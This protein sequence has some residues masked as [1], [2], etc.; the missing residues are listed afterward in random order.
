MFA[1]PQSITYATVA[2][3][4][5]AISRGDGQSEYRLNDSGTVYHLTLSHQFKARNRVVIRLRRDAYAS[6]PVVPTSN[7]LASATCSFTCDFPNVGYTATDVSNL[8]QA[9]VDWLSDANLLKMINGE[10]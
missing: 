2:K 1:D 7:V 6:D 4:L 3:S 9:L 10:T 5:P 8:A